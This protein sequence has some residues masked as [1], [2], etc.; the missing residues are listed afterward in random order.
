MK[1][2]ELTTDAGLDVLCEI[3]IP[4]GNI[5]TD[6]AL[7][8]ELKNKTKLP[9]TA[10][11]PEIYSAILAKLSKL[12]PIILKTHRGDVYA[13]VGAVNGKTEGDIAQQSLLKTAA[14]IRDIV[15]DK[16][17]KDFFKSLWSTAQK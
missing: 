10:T 1:I 11:T 2:S 8:T 5:V 6:E 16:E 13:I 14:E 4:L 9:D 15:N 12:L 3:T 17:F 7:V